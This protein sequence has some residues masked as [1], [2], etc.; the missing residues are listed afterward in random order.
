MNIRRLAL[1]SSRNNGETTSFAYVYY[2]C[3]E[4]LQK[5]IL[6]ICVFKCETVSWTNLELWGGNLYIWNTFMIFMFFQ[7]KYRRAITT[8][9]DAVSLPCILPGPASVSAAGTG[10]AGSAGCPAIPQYTSHFH[11][12]YKKKNCLSAKPIQIL[13]P[14]PKKTTK[15]K[16]HH[17]L[18][19]NMK[20]YL[21]FG[22]P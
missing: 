18:F 12:C 8:H 10:P 3:A 11:I 4:A 17:F 22:L 13:S 7:N 5:Q 20:N 15:K 9:T 21:P 14:P 16:Q 6:H 1:L 19:L 2:S